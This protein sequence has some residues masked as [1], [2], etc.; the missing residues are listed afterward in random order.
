[1]ELR[2]PFN[3]FKRIFAVAG[4]GVFAII[5]WVATAKAQVSIFEDPLNTRPGAAETIIPTQD[6]IPAPEDLRSPDGF[7]Q[8]YDQ[9]VT[10][11]LVNNTEAEIVYRVVDH[12]EERLLAGN[13]SVDLADIPI[14][15]TV[16]FYTRD[17]RLLNAEVSTTADAE[18]QVQLTLSGTTLL[19]EN[20]N[21]M[22]VQDSG[23]IFLQ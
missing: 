7:I 8:A 10:I 2:S 16:T 13:E 20:Q 3:R 6:P 12:T 9:P 22:I 4:S 17:G 19:A 14:P 21:S 5:A 1:M 23:Y 11:T 18:S 15:V